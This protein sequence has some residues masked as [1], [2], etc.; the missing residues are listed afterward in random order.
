[1]IIGKKYCARKSGAGALKI[2]IVEFEEGKEKT[3]LGNMFHSSVRDIGHQIVFG[4][5]QCR[6]W[7]NDEGTSKET[8]QLE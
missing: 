6:K 8:K 1:M 2:S 5:R 7:G 3:W 4:E